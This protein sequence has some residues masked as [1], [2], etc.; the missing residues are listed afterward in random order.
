MY[1]CEILV[2]FT[3]TDVVKLEYGDVNAAADASTDL[4]VEIGMIVILSV[5]ASM[6][7]DSGGRWMS[8]DWGETT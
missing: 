4:S 2:H 8:L 3:D 6:C 5:A 7:V 1:R